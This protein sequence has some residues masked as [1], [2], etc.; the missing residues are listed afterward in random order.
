M[1]FLSEY[2]LFLAKTATFV[3][4]VIFV[5]GI[6]TQMR[7]QESSAEGNLKITKLNDQLNAHRHSLA[8]AVLDKKTLKQKQKLWKKSEKEKE[9]GSDASTNVYV[10][11]FKGDIQ[12]KTVQQ[13]REEITILLTQAT[14][15]DEVVIRL[16]SGGG[17][18]HGYGLAASQ[19]DR[20]RKKGIKLTVAIDKVAASGGY[21]MACVADHIIA[22]PF[23]ILGSIGVVGQVPNFNRLLEKHEVDF[24]MHTSGEYKR[25]LTMLGKNTDKGREKFVQDL[26]DTHKLFKSFVAEHRPQLDIETVATGEVWYGRQAI[27]KNLVDEIATSD[28]YLCALI[29]NKSVVHVQYTQRKKLPEKLA[30][31]V[32]LTLDNT[33]DKLADKIRSSNFLS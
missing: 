8:A 4:A 24:E 1:E 5:L 21:M 3:V 7:R 17:V 19:L 30:S 27:D 23:A 20:I 10:L 11:D 14:D 16:E 13:L 2:G 6:A 33:I 9:G 29:E 32:S 15:K 18:V 28:E 25:T 31:S 26:E 22:A 12:A